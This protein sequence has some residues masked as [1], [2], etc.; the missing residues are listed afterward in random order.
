MS[1]IVCSLACMNHKTFSRDHK[2]YPHAICSIA[3]ASVHLTIHPSSLDLI[4]T[5][6]KS[7]IK[8]TC[9]VLISYCGHNYYPFFAK[10]KFFLQ[11]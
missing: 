6:S 7:I 1:L 5:L 11:Q 4:Y 2:S 9:D 8:A 3:A 10:K